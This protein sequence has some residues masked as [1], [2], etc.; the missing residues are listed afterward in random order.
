MIVGSEECSKTR[1][2]EKRKKKSKKEIKK[3][4][5]KNYQLEKWIKSKC[6]NFERIWKKQVEFK[7][8]KKLGE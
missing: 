5:K 7:N 4:I 3:E 8:K 1:K 2:K 6:I